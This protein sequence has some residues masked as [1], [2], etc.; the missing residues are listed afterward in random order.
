ML[1]EEWSGGWYREA[2]IVIRKVDNMVVRNPIA[3]V[4]SL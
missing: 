3:E 4:R 2:C 1:E